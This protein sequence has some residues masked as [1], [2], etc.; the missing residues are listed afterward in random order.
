MTFRRSAILALSAII[1]SAFVW[2]SFRGLSLQTNLSAMLPEQNL[3]EQVR[4]VEQNMSTLATN[5]LLL[6]IGAPN[7]AY[8]D[9]AIYDFELAIEDSK[10]LASTV[11]EAAF[12][13]TLLPL[14]KKHRFQLLTDE[15]Q[16]HLQNL[17]P[18]Q[19]LEKRTAE[20]KQEFF[21][22][23]NFSE[24]PFGT[25]NHYLDGISEGSAK[26]FSA[27]WQGRP[28]LFKTLLLTSL[29]SSLEIE[30]QQ[31]IVRWVQNQKHWLNNDY[32]A[33]LLGTGVVF[34]AEAAARSAKKE[35]STIATISSIGVVLLCLFIF[36]SLR[37]LILAISAITFGAMGAFVVCQ[38]FFGGVQLLTLVFGASLIGVAV[39]YVIHLGVHAEASGQQILK[40]LTKPMTISLISSLAGYAALYASGTKGLQEIACFSIS[41]LVFA[42]F[43]VIGIGPEFLQRG[44]PPHLME[45]LGN[46]RLRF[47]YQW[48]ANALIFTLAIAAST[49]IFLKL[50]F[51]DDPRLMYASSKQLLDETAFVTQQ[52]E[53]FDSSRYLVITADNASELAKRIDHIR[54]QI[55]RWKKDGITSD[56]DWLGRW[57]PSE[58]QQQSSTQHYQKLFAEPE[59]L[60]Q[61]L[62]KQ[63]LTQ[64]AA[65]AFVEAFRA[66]EVLTAD[67]FAS[68]L[69]NTMNTPYWIETHHGAAAVLRFH[70]DSHTKSLIEYARNEPHIFWVDRV[71]ELHRALSNL[72]E[73]ALR[74]LILSHLALAGLIALLMNFRSALNVVLVP[75]LSNLVCAA[76]ILLTQ[77]G[78]SLFHVLGFY[79][80]LGLGI[81]YAVFLASMAN[82]ESQQRQ[83]A[84]TVSAL[85]SLLAFGLLSLSTTPFV[86]Q[87]G[88]TILIGT[89]CNL[90]LAMLISPP[91]TQSLPGVK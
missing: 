60:I 33:V 14:L 17:T 12:F 56:V 43:M 45:K 11:D 10:H 35:I 53:T 72:R 44:P 6:V 30:K 82:H 41:G 40:R 69:S 32:E 21:S 70:K 74:Y 61:Q 42:F 4:A 62:G 25:L 23:I 13:D 46:M 7:E 47:S 73:Q 50:A 5:K 77:Q 49:V 1:M 86:Q 55:A 2:L 15:D 68:V 8:L 90:I 54:P 51:A 83:L 89:F 63:G 52:S 48:Q 31:A 39:D 58:A 38:I 36:R 19:L 9:D 66:S 84:V 22:F 71:T 88:L 80:V 27:H 18:N 75:V 24:D 76:F 65:I 64:D 16:K 3:S 91:K 59:Q 29:D 26:T 87:F 20:R 85:T 57:L 34:F 78:L 67:R 37:P 81:D 79:L 28:F